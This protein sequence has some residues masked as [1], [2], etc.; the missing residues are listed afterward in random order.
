MPGNEIPHHNTPPQGPGAPRPTTSPPQGPPTDLTFVPWAEKIRRSGE[1]RE[2]PLH[3]GIRASGGVH[4]GCVW[5]KNRS[6][7]ATRGARAAERRGGVNNKTRRFLPAFGGLGGDTPKWQGQ[8]CGRSWARP[9]LVSRV[10]P[11]DVHFHH[12]KHPVSTFSLNAMQ[13][14][15]NPMFLYYMSFCTRFKALCID[16]IAIRNFME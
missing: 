9:N 3:W 1:R 16:I 2:D 10:F 5:E 4:H 7:G 8:G 12:C 14:V 6:H 15:S 13:H 11:F